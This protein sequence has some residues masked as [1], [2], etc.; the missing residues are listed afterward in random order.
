MKVTFAAILLL[1]KLEKDSDKFG[2]ENNALPKLK[3][4]Q[5]GKCVVLINVWLVAII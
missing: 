3:I 2:C 5:R 4:Q 1:Q